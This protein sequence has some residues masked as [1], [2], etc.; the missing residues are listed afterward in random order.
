VI[1]SLV[2][3]AA[4]HRD[5]GGYCWQLA[6]S[7]APLLLRG[8][9]FHDYLATQETAIAA[10]ERLGDPLGQGIAHYEYAHACALLGETGDSGA[11]LKQ[12]LD[13]FATAGD[14]VGSAAS[15]DGLAQLLMQEGD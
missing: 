1:R 4:G 10:A 14:Q 8:G 6:W 13:R 15:L 9:L 11:H 12:A 5:L 3:Y 2:T 7:M